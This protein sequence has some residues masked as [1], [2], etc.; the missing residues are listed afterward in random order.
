MSRQFRWP[1]RLMPRW[2]RRCALVALAPFEVML[3]IVM[4]C[5][6]AIK[7]AS[8]NLRAGWNQS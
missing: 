8:E 1:F 2:G 4:A 5:G 6:E 7:L 3:Q